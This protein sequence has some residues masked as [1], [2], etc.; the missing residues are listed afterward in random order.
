MEPSKMLGSITHGVMEPSNLLDSIK[1]GMMELNNLLDSFTGRRW[2][3]S[4]R[5]AW[6]FAHY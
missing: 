1:R 5:A 2:A 4:Q 6:N 3:P